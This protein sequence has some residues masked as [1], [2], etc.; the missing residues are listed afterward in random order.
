MMEQ[1]NWRMVTLRLRMEP[2]ILDRLVTLWECVLIHV[3][4]YENYETLLLG[5]HISPGVQTLSLKNYTWNLFD[6]F[7]SRV[8]ACMSG[9]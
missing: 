7:V 2:T 5:A 6:N 8:G 4:L 3:C 9:H 1:K